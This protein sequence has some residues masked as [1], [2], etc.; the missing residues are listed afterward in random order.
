MR[1]AW[2]VLV[3]S[4]WNEQLVDGAFTPDQW[5]HFQNELQLLPPPAGDPCHVAGLD[6]A[7]HDLGDML[8]Q[9][10]QLSAL[11]NNTLVSC[12][13]CHDPKHAWIDSRVP[14]NVSQGATKF[15]KHNALTM[16]NLVYK[17]G[18]ANANTFTWIGQYD[19]PGDV[20]TKIAIPKAMN[21]SVT[22]VATVIESNPTYAAL[23]AKAFG[24]GTPDEQTIQQTFEAYLC[25]DPVF[26]TG[27]TPF[28][29]YLRGDDQAAAMS[30]SAKRGFAIF[31]GRGTCIEC[32]KGPMFTDYDFHATGVPQ[33]GQN[34]QTTDNGLFDTTGDPA[35]TGKFL[36]PSLREVAHTAPYMHDGAFDTL[37]EVIAFYRGGGGPPGVAKDPRIVPLDLDDNDA[38]DLEAF[39]NALSQCVEP[40]CAP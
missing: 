30:D 1:F 32:H 19:N 22:Q 7:A 5:A 8:F 12:E 34:V 3:A 24:P 9:D 10:A 26:F 23:Y 40:T 17:F 11:P 6:P 38:L 29:H 25:T 16:L 13:S 20:I 27:L 31:V 28:D 37:A 35:D 21:S 33:E 14:D 2:V 15:T 39:L 18:H 36:V 4:C